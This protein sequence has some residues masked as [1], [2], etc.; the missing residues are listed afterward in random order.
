[1]RA[2][3]H[4]RHA[5]WPSALLARR[6]P[7]A[8]AP[9]ATRLESRSR[10]RPAP[11]QPPAAGRDRPRQRP[12]DLPAGGPRA[13]AGPRRRAHP[14]R[15][16][17]GARREGRPGQPLRAGLAHGRHQVTHRRPARRLPRGARRPRGDR[18]RPRLHHDLLGLP[19]R[20]LRRGLP[21]VPGAAAKPEFREDKLDLAKTADQ[22]R[23]R[24][25]QRR[26][27]AGSPAAKR[28][29]L[30]YG[31][32]S[33]YARVRR[34]R[35]ASRAVTR[36]DLL[37]WHRDVRPPEQHR[38]LGVVGRLRRRRPWRRRCARPSGSWPRG[39]AARKVE[40]AVQRPE[41]RRLLRPEGRREPE[42]HPHGA[43]RHRPATTPTTTRSR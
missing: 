15:L 41:A 23:H 40:A 21:R 28:A 38:S 18:R 8:A 33:P 2:H 36:D 35:D 16:P 19:R 11:F 42:Q 6:C 31:A 26:R 29:Q 4:D 37:A 22:H 25:A 14:R 20:K 9:Q 10:S 30:G 27:R 39:P 34:V 13:A 43:P 7:G 1:M 3:A 5:S 32:D 17:G 12:G 24:P